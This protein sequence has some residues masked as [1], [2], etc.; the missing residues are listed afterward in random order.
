MVVERR[1][2]LSRLRRASTTRARL[3]GAFIALM[4]VAL[5]VSLVVQRG[6]LLAQMSADVDAQ[7]R[8]EAEEFMSLAGGLNPETGVPFGGDIEA[9]FTVFF[10]RNVPDEG[11]AV[12]TLVAGT[13][14]LST[15]APLQLLADTSLVA[16]WAA[17]ADVEDDEVATAAGDVRWLA[18]PMVHEGRVTGTFV[19]AVFLQGRL[20]SINR[21]IWTGLLTFGSAFVL[22]SGLAWIVAGRVLQ[23]LTDLTEAAHS[24]NE[25]DW[26]Q[27]INVRGDDQIAFLA[28]TFNEMLD[29]LES[30]F[31]AQARLID[32]AGHELRTPL[33]IVRGHLELISHDPAERE[34]TLGLVMEEL[35][36]MGRMVDDLLLL[37]HAEQDGFLHRH[38]V[39]I[40]TFVDDIARKAR[41]LGDRGWTVTER[42]PVVGMA[43]QQRLTQAMMNLCRNAV[44]HTPP[45]VAVLLGSRV[46]GDDVHLW[47]ADDGPGV[48]SAE[49]GRI[50]DRF[51]RGEHVDP[52]TGGAGLGLAIA[53]IIAEAHGGRIMVESGTGAGSRFVIA[54]PLERPE[55][56]IR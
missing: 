28:Q 16:R 9:I 37:A 33:T 10:A 54:L 18:V 51:A 4:A 19:V 6:I 55:G 45:D 31:T 35:D 8:Q 23:P 52:S 32:D 49:Q 14:Y 56:G 43:D 2:R 38:P 26:T 42:A 25:A 3:L 36:H 27:R 34:E 40:D 29:R 11:E 50:F 1:S 22:A 39:D 24:V 47:V 46:V 20:D 21:V 13:P 5:V 53:R 7:L 41:M 12:F 15:P 44:E 17:L 30:A 48:P